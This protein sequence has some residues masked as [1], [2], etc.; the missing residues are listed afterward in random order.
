[1]AVDQEKVHIVRGA[2]TIRGLPAADPGSGAGLAAG[3]GAGGIRQRSGRLGELLIEG[4]HVSAAQLEEALLRQRID[5]LACLSASSRDLPP[6]NS[7]AWRGWAREV[8]V[9][10]GEVFIHRDFGSATASS[11][12]PAAPCR[13][14]DITKEPKKQTLAILGAGESI[15]ENGLFHR[16][17]AHRIRARA[18]RPDPN[19][20]CLSYGRPR[21]VLQDRAQPRRRFPSDHYPPA[22]AS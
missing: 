9:E 22:C 6:M 14:S 17:P 5:R 15:G 1:M 21:R 8:S 10:Q 16:R 13:S 19:L 4:G 2:G 20:L 11:S 18:I 7:C 12:S 3:A